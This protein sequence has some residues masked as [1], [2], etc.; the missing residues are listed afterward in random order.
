M[1]KNFIIGFKTGFIEFIN[2]F[3]K[4]VLKTGFY[5]LAIL[6]LVDMILQF[7]TN[8]EFK[9]IHTILNVLF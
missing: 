1:Y 7:L 5:L 3:F 4:H 8:K 6:G 2:F 9:L